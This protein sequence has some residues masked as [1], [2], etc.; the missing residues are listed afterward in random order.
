MRVD[1]VFLPSDLKPSH[2]QNR[3]VVVLDVLRAT[4]TMAAALQAGVQE[5]FV[6]PDIEA[7]RQAKKQMPRA[8]ACGEH[9]CLKPQGFDL[10]NSPADFGEQHVGK[11]LLMCTTNGT[12]AI[13]AARG[14]SR[15]FTGAIVN[16]RAVG[17]KV[18][19]VGKDVTLLCA[20]TTGEVAMEDV[21]GAGA[22][23]LFSG[24]IETADT[25]LMAREL[26]LACR[27]DLLRVLR[28]TAGGQNI[29]RANLDKDI[30]F[31]ARINA[32]S[33]VGEVKEGEAIR[34]V[35]ATS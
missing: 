12:K 32:L 34:V 8:L 26:F 5:I 21:L 15:I 31:A 14:A 4:T 35:H 6:Y 19:E 28:S 20:G 3:V 7:V 17:K 18:Q 33:A 16:A 30:D 24:E 29:I 1:V 25:T 13:L 23:S 11:N 27:N 10:G 9:Q 2:L 22:I